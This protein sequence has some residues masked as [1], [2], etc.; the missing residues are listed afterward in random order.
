MSRTVVDIRDGDFFINGVPTYAGRTWNGRRIEGLLFN[1]RMVQGIFDDRNPETSSRWNYPD[2]PWDPQRNTSEFIA[3]MP[4]WQ[5]HGVNTFTLNLQGGSPEGY[6]RHQPW[7]NSAFEPDGSLRHDYF[8]RA[9]KILRRADELGMTVILGLFYFA[10]DERLSDEA[11][12]IRATDNTINWLLAGK[13]TNVI[14][15]TNNE[16]DHGRYEH[17]ILRP[18]RVAELLERIRQK[19]RGRVA[20]VAGRLLAGVSLCGGHVH[21]N[22]LVEAS[23]VI[24]LH[25]N[26]VEQPA[27]IRAMVDEVRTRPAWSGQPVVFNEDDH[28]AFDQPDYN[29]LAAIDRH[30]SWGFFDFRRPGEDYKEGYQSVPVDWSISSS[31]KNAF[32]TRV[33]E[34]IIS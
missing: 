29:M 21:D 11:A 9:E 24:F 17:A 10:Q 32:F 23:D 27:R 12:V 5:A 7:E 28:Y 20:N 6:S 1:S 3:A 33:H 15:E 2:G 13:Y 8:E 30:A 18:P 26:G 31:R 16:A 14:I 19:S 25:G 34:I 4:D 22:A